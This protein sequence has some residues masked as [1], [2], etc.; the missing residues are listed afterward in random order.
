[1]FIT[2]ETCLLQWS[3]SCVFVCWVS[4]HIPACSCFCTLRVQWCSHRWPLRPHCACNHGRPGLQL[5]TH[6]MKPLSQ[7]TS[8]YPDGWVPD[9]HQNKPWS[10]PSRPRWNW[11]GE[12]GTNK[13]LTMIGCVFIFFEHMKHAYTSPSCLQT[14]PALMS[15]QPS[16][17]TLPHWPLINTSMR[18]SLRLSPST[19]LTRGPGTTA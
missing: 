17:H 19:S 4:N 1:M 2:V 3:F 8:H 7:H 14:T 5:N 16:S 13:W 12:R 6:P 11:K 15:F 10:G 18:P 9:L